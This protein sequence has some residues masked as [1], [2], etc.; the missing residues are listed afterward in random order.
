MTLALAFLALA[1]PCLILVAWTLERRE[2]TNDHRETIAA[3]ERERTAWADERRELLNR[4]K[5]E[6]AQFAPARQVADPAPVM[7]DDDDSYWAT[8]TA[9]MSK[10]EL[11]EAIDRQERQ[12]A[13]VMAPGEADA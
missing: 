2:R 13:A 7:F 8:A 11:A 1:L 10:E 6:T 12:M 9:G 3:H 4:I 5:P